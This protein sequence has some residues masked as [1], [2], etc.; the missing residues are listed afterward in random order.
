[1][2]DKVTPIATAPASTPSDESKTGT[3]AAQAKKVE[4][5]KAGPGTIPTAKG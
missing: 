2:N 4:E 1:M 5:A 3:Q